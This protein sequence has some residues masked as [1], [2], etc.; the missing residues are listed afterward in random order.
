MEWMDNTFW[1]LVALVIFLA[2]VVYLK[3]PGTITK[4]LDERGERISRELEEARKLREEAQTL[5]ASYQRKQREAQ[6]EA[7]EI[8]EAA[9]AEAGRM[10]EETREELSVQ[11]DRRT[12]L[13]EE[14]I[15][16]AEAQAMAEVQSIAADAAVGAARVVIASKTD[17]AADAK[18]VDADIAKL[19]SQIG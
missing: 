19:G 1:T 8:V 16:A 14:K 4:S 11:L 9:K 7:D 2:G 10:I 15:K 13:A 18:I 12:K 6:A 5:L 17:A 3:V